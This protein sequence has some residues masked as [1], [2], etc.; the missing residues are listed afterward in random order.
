MTN[1]FK[2]CAKQLNETEVCAAFCDY[3]GS[4]CP[5]SDKRTCVT[6][7]GFTC[8]WQSHNATESF[9]PGFKYMCHGEE[10]L[11]KNGILVVK[12]FKYFLLEV[13]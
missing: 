10:S 13:F 4:D 8:Q 7:N 9:A 5:P 3:D 6:D 1:S 12:F 2:Y 11:S